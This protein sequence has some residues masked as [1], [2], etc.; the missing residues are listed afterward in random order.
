MKQ[1]CNYKRI[2]IKGEEHIVKDVEKDLEYLKAL[3]I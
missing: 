3:D 1:Q 2:D